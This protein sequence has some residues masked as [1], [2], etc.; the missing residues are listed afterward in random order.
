MRALDDEGCH[1]R[2]QNVEEEHAGSA[3]P[4]DP[5]PST[6]VCSRKLSTWA[7]TTRTTR[8]ISGTTSA[9]M[10]VSTLAR[11]RAIK[12]RARRMDEMAMRPS[13][14]RMTTMSSAR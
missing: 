2:G 6:I 10:T 12:A 4:D 5:R 9:T 3:R 8:G 1:Q 7:R 13:T 11:T 14:M